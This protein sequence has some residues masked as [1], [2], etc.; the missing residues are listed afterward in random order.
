MIKISNLEKLN[1]ITKTYF[2]RIVEDRNE[3]DKIW[4]HLNHLKNEMEQI[5][6]SYNNIADKAKITNTENKY[7][8][9]KPQLDLV[10]PSIIEAVGI[11]RTYGTEKY[12]SPDGWKEVEPKRYIAALM[13]HLCAF[14]RNPKA[15][16]TESGYP[17]LW[18]MACNI[19]FLC[20]FYNKEEN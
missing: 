10:P 14:L 7:D 15:K 1:K 20:E 18:H 2:D 5:Y 11:I 6:T 8:Q 12:G 3:A 19:A 9:G 16:D 13:R 4:L 17:H